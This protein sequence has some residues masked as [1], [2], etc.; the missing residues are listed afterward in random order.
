MTAFTRESAFAVRRLASDREIH[1]EQPANRDEDG[2]ENHTEHDPDTT[3]GHGA[4]PEEIENSRTR[5]LREV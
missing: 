2:E 5:E 4:P 1:H 3:L